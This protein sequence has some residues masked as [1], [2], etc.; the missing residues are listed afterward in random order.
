MKS[1]IQLVKF[2][3][4]CLLFLSFFVFNSSAGKGTALYTDA[5]SDTGGG[6]D[7]IDIAN[8]TTSLNTITVFYYGAISI[9][10][11]CLG[12][13]YDL[14]IDTNED[15]NLDGDVDYL[16]SDGFG[17]DDINSTIFGN[18]ITDDI[19]YLTKVSTQL[20]FYVETITQESALIMQDHTLDKP[21]GTIT[22]SDRYPD[23][24]W[25]SDSDVFAP[26]I[27]EFSN[28]FIPFSIFSVLIIVFTI[29]RNNKNK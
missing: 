16:I 1:K 22:F 6:A 2:I 14:I 3:I 8:I 11:C 26:V 7:F 29:T 9:G 17:N 24:G 20:Q 27:P 15:G 5:S 19:S 28:W 12:G 13:L 21:M 10:V 18:M 23:S 4:V 25:Q